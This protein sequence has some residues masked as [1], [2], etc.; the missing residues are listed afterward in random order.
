MT[1]G[2]EALLPVTPDGIWLL[3][4]FVCEES[5]YTHSLCVRVYKSCFIKQLPAVL[6]PFLSRQL[7]ITFYD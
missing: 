2:E 7:T 6:L 4:P 3:V 5:K 1:G